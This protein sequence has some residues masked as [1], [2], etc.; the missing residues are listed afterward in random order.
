MVSV[1]SIFASE[2]FIMLIVWLIVVGLGIIIEAQTSDLVSIWF[3]LAGAVAIVCALAGVEIYIQILVFAII[4]LILVIATRP[5]IKKLT[6]NTEVKTNSDKLV[7]MVGIVE[8]DIEPNQ[9]GIVRVEFQEWSAV[10]KK[11]IL[12]EKGTRV[13]IMEIV[14][15]K[16]I[17]DSVEEIEI[18]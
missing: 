17:V 6:N 10:S 9:K 7:G 15:N 4:T 13:V 14:G 5:F 3:S 16:L 12:I 2:K 1:L 18:K 8:A 11:N